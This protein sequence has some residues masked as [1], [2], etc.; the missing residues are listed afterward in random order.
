MNIWQFQRLVSQRLLQWAGVNIV[1]GLLLQRMNPFW[2]GLGSQA[3]GWGLV[4]AAIGLFGLI[5]RDQRIA[6]ISNPG[7]IEVRAE[8]S[9]KLGRL[10]WINAG[11]DVLYI[12]GGWLW[13]RSDGKN[14]RRRGEGVGVMIQGLFL[15][16]FD[17]VHAVKL[18]RD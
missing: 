11:L 7:E 9:R 13:S 5:S 6:G 3:T 17:I 4:N 8:E 12:L 1:S 15:L 18:P 16:V 10:L 14:Q 2:R